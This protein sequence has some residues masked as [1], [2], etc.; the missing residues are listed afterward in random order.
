MAVVDY[1]VGQNLRYYFDR[2]AFIEA[3]MP[4][5]YFYLDRPLPEHYRLEGSRCVIADLA[6]ISPAY[7]LGDLNAY[8]RPDEWLRYFR[9]VFGLDS[10][11]A[12]V[13]PESIEI[14]GGGETGLYAWFR[15]APGAAADLDPLFARLDQEWAA[16][17][18]GG[19][20]PFSAWRARTGR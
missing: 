19:G 6:L 14:L 13:K 10:E 20:K 2:N 11:G 8:D 18:E 15:S 12:P 3:Q 16:R 5:F 7:S 9:W 1:A 17:G 4:L